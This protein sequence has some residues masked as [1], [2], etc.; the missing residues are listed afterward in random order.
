MWIN[1]LVTAVIGVFSTILAAWLQ[2]RRAW[3]DLR[4][5]LY[6]D[7]LAAMVAAH[8]ATGEL[9]YL[10]EEIHY[11]KHGADDEHHKALQQKRNHLVSEYEKHI[12]D[13]RRFSAHG[14]LVLSESSVNFLNKLIKNLN[15]Q[16]G[17]GNEFDFWNARDGRLQAALTDFK[18]L[19][20]TD[21][22]LRARWWPWCQRQ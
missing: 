22:G 5:R 7:L 18:R 21:L 19:A 17:E 16:A 20:R 11:A 8:V 14:L 10:M 13:I 6:G 9:V 1:W 12:S 4:L 2:R 15:V 3:G